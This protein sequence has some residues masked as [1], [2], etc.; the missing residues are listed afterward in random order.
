MIKEV[1]ANYAEEN[2]ILADPVYDRQGKMIYPPGTA[3]TIFNRTQMYM[4]GV[5]TIRVYPRMLDYQ[6]QEIIRPEIQEKLSAQMRQLV[7]I[8]GTDSDANQEFKIYE[9]RAMMTSV[10]ED[11]LK[12]EAVMEKL[13]N[14]R[15]AYE[16]LYQHSVGVM[17][18]AM[19][20]GTS[21]GISKT[22]LK[23]LGRAAIFHDIGMLFI[24]LEIMEKQRLSKDEYQ[25]IKSHPLKSYLFLKDNAN[26]DQSILRAILEHHERWDGSGY[27]NEKE[28]DKIDENAQ[29]IGLADT[30]DS[31][32]N[33]RP[34]RKAYSV[35]E[36]HEFIMSQAGTQFNPKL[37]KEFI[38]NINPYPINTLVEMNDGSSAVVIKTNTPYHT[39]PVIKAVNGPLRGKHINLLEKRSFTIIKT[40]KDPGDHI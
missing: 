21:L 34:Y 24:P 36:V 30:F 19:L 15:T 28:G 14:M 27:P 3:V 18:N 35:S 2:S 16:Y 32:I 20:L 31:M 5:E 29:I 40:L 8:R 1:K 7:R 12:E 37:V 13:A 23:S 4:E 22:Q 6:K 17:I 11:F 38:R 10:V 33:E 26:L 39:R 9:V 25:I